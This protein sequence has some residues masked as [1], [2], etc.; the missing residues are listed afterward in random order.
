M[1]TDCKL[2]PQQLHSES[3]LVSRQADTQVTAF[4]GAQNICVLAAGLA[5]FTLQASLPCCVCCC[6]I[7]YNPAESR[8]AYSLE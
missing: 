1:D 3:T 5:C 6:C 7:M 8:E 2:R 4:A